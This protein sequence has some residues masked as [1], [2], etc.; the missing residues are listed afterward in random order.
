MYRKPIYIYRVH[1]IWWY[2][3]GIDGRVSYMRRNNNNNWRRHHNAPGLKTIIIIYFPFLVCFCV[4]YRDNITCLCLARAEA[5]SKIVHCSVVP[6]EEG[7][8]TRRRG[9]MVVVGVSCRRRRLYYYLATAKTVTIVHTIRHRINNNNDTDA[10]LN[11]NN[12]RGCGYNIKKKN[13]I[14]NTVR[15][16]STV[17]L[18]LILFWK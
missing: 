10:W 8:G 1:S 11:G 17:L 16:V 2:T 7:E 9:P 3:Y 13:S 6:G 18:L 15:A 4:T 14:Y 5:F 12:E